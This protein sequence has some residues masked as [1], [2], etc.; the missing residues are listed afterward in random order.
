Q[1]KRFERMI[2]V[3]RK[4]AAVLAGKEI[5]ASQWEALDLAAMSVYRE[6]YRSAARF[7]TEALEKDP[8]LRD[9]P[10]FGYRPRAACAAVM[11]ATGQGKDAAGLKEQERAALRRQALDWLRADLKAQAALQQ[12]NRENGPIIQLNL[13]AW[14]ADPKLASVRDD[15]AL[16]T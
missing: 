12:K 10:L 16:A 9:D 1:L 3:D 15:G 2:E 7:Y 6:Q 13:R 5:P 4:L 11:A 14:Q 8:R